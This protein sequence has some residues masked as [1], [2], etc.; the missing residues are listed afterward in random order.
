MVSTISDPT[1]RRRIE[2]GDFD[3]MLFAEVDLYVEEYQRLTSMTIGARIRSAGEVITPE[4][5]NVPGQRFEGTVTDNVIEGIFEIESRV[6]DGT[7]RLPFPVDYSDDPELEKWLG[8]SLMIEADDPRLI[9][10]AEEIIGETD[11][12]WEAVQ[13]LARWVGTEIGG[14]VPGASARQT[15]DRGS[16][17]CGSHS[18]LFAA[19]CR[20]VGIP[21]RLAMGG[22][23][24]PLKDGSFGQHVWNEVWMGAAGWISLDT[25]FQEFDYIDAGHL[26]LGEMT[27]F[28]PEEMEV[29]EHRLGP[30]R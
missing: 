29:L 18:R 20:A 10:A 1:V 28:F 4:S 23:Y 26:R 2:V 3:A 7:G 13:R 21:C 24:T 14:S 17:E 16:G 27:G 19:F 9:A 22:A 11:D 25:T 30:P 5:L 6:F 8:P 12:C 15:F